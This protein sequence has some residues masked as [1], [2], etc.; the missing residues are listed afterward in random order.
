MIKPAKMKRMELISKE[1]SIASIYI[2]Y[3]LLFCL[4]K[5]YT[6]QI[7]PNYLNSHGEEAQEKP[8]GL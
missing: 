2:V 7:K 6:N 8:P 4:P 3:C 5:K 1:V